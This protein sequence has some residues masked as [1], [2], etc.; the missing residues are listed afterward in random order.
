MDVLEADM[1]VD[2]DQA[3]EDAVKHGVQR[4]G[5]ERRNGD[6]Q[7]SY[8]DSPGAHKQISITASHTYPCIIYRV[9]SPLHTPMQTAMTGR[10]LGCL[11]RI[12]HRPKDLLRQRRKDLSLLRRL[13]CRP[14][15]HERGRAKD[16]LQLAL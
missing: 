13:K 16:G 7:D 8:G 2:E 12:V 9:L 14:L 10:G 5:G 6:G 3:D 1:R 4:A 11:D 15:G